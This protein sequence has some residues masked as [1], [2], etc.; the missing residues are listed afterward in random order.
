[1]R[2]LLNLIHFAWFDTGILWLRSFPLEVQLTSEAQSLTYTIQ[3]SE[4]SE[5]PEGEILLPPSDRAWHIIGFSCNDQR[6]Q[7]VVGT[8]CW[9]KASELHRENPIHVMMGT[10]TK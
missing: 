2:V 7:E 8:A 4:S 10:G 6:Q 5:T 1:M 9:Q 3:L